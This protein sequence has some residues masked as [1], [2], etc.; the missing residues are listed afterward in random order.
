[1]LHWHEM[2]AT[3]KRQWSAAW[4]KRCKAIHREPAGELP[5]PELIDG[6]D[7]QLIEKGG[8]ITKRQFELMALE[9]ARKGPADR[10]SWRYQGGF[11]LP[12]EAEKKKMERRVERLVEENIKEDGT[13]NIEWVAE[14]VVKGFGMIEG[15]GVG[16]YT[17]CAHGEV[18]DLVERIYERSRMTAGEALQIAAELNKDPRRRAPRR[19]PQV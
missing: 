2:T 14:Q 17:E 18:A 5:D 19:G 4:V 9:Y 1:L 11:E 8:T 10:N 12:T 7:Q 15:P 16:F 3:E 6:W 13:L